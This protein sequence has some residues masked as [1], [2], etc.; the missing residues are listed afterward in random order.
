MKPYGGEH[1]SRDREL[2][3]TKTGAKPGKRKTESR[4]LRK[5]KRRAQDRAEL[6]KEGKE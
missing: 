1:K 2:D 6:K 3:S 5:K 4:R